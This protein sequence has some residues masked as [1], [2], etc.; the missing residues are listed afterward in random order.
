MNGSSTL[1]IKVEA[2]EKAAIAEC[3]G[4]YN[5]NISRAAGA[6]GLSRVGLRSKL[7]RYDLKKDTYDDEE[8]PR[9]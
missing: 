5:G 9:L 3:L 2:L 7:S 8:S 6:L 4:R 1:K